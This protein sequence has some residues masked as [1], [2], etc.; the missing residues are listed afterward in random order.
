MKVDFC[1]ESVFI[2]F[3]S[4]PRT[5]MFTYVLVPVK[6]KVA[7]VHSTI[8]PLIEVG[9]LCNVTSHCTCYSAVLKL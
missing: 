3:M 4:T 2:I 9:V 7:A 1:M 8:R 5:F 6:H